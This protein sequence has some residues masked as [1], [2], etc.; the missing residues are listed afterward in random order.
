MSADV[1]QSIANALGGSKP[2]NWNTGQ[3]ASAT[4]QALAGIVAQQQQRAAGG[5]IG[6]IDGAEQLGSLSGSLSAFGSMSM[7]FA[8][9]QAVRQN[10]GVEQ[11]ALASVAR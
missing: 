6:G 1:A 7:P 3:S 2:M 5:G 8:A 10:A 9:L 4:A 11:Q